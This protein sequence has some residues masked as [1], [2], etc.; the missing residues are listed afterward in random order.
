MPFSL[1]LAITMD[2][3]EIST[4]GPSESESSGKKFVMENQR[5]CHV[6]HRYIG[7]WEQAG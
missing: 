7:I 6:F 5:Q 2:S 4:D 3:S 1:K